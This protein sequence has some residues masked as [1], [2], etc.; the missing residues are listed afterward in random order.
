LTPDYVSERNSFNELI[1][2]EFEV[3]RS[4]YD[5]D[6]VVRESHGEKE[7]RDLLKS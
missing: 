4:K 5:D 3:L 6:C 1:L 7:C 2:V